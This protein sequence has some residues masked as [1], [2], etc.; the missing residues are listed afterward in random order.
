MTG[1]LDAL[2]KAAEALARIARELDK[3]V[4]N[5]HFYAEDIVASLAADAEN[6]SRVALTHSSG[7]EI[8]VYRN[9]GGLWLR[10]G[11]AAVSLDKLLEAVPELASRLIREFCEALVEEFT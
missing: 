4:V 10:F 3:L 9:D 11:D 8:V 6:A 5:R 2:T 7:S 1:Q